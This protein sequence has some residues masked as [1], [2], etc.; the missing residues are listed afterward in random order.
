MLSIAELID[1]LIIE[2]MKIFSLREQ[3]HKEDIT[4]E[5]YVECENKMNILNENRGTLMDFLNTKVDKVLSGEEK[6]QALRNVKTYAKS[7]K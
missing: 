7:K 4:D 5:E 6:N 3:I 2:N 1:K